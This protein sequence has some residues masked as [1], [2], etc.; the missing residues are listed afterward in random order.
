M[1]DWKAILQPIG[2]RPH[3]PH[4]ALRAI[5][6]DVE[7]LAMPQPFGGL[8]V[9]VTQISSRQAYQAEHVI[10]REATREEVASFMVTVFESIHPDRPSSPSK[11][12]CQPE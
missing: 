12:E 7:Y 11:V 1:D 10:P 6:E 8:S 3:G 4:G 2:F 5:V 9:H